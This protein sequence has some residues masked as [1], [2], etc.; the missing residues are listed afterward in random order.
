MNALSLFR[1][2]SPEQKTAIREK[3]M[4]GKHSIRSWIRLLHGLAQFDAKRDAGATKL[5]VLTTFVCLFTSVFFWIVLSSYSAGG[6][7]GPISLTILVLMLVLSFW[8]FRVSRTM[9][10]GDLPNQLRLVV[11]PLLR[12][13]A[14]ETSSRARVD[15][16]HRLYGRT[17]KKNLISGPTKLTGKL[18]NGWKSAKES[19]YRDEWLLLD[20]FLADKTRMA[21]QITDITRRFDVTKRGSSGKIKSK[22]KYKIQTRISAHFLPPGSKTWVTKKHVERSKD[23]KE[24]VSVDTILQLI[25]DYYAGS[26]SGSGSRAP[27]KGKPA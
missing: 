24:I 5:Y 2:L 15:M 1:Q 25:S 8:L 14:E 20:A 6:R 18:P 3:T 12:V 22:T 17:H 23:E 9:Y 27:V 16:T 19:R 11:Y 26:Y 13:L 4:F 7:P 10:K 21:L